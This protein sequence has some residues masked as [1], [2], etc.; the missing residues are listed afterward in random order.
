[1]NFNEIANELGITWEDNGDLMEELEEAIELDEG[2]KECFCRYEL[3][4]AM[5]PR[6][7]V[8]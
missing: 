8:I 6:H 1:M 7:G 4:P 2:N 3:T 5:C